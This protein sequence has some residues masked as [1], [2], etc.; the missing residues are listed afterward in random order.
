MTGVTKKTTILVIYFCKALVILKVS[1]KKG[2]SLAA[3]LFFLTYLSF[4]Q[5]RPRPEINLD[6]FIQ[7]IFPLQQ[8]NINYED[9]YESLFQLYQHPINLNTATY[10]ELSSLYVLS[11]AQIKSLLTHRTQYGDLLSIYELQA[12]AGFDMTTIQQLLPFIEVRQKFNAKSLYNNVGHINDHYLV[13][14]SSQTL[15]KSRAYKENKYPGSPQQLYARYR[16]SSPR[17]FQIG[18]VAEKDAGEKNYLDFYSFHLQLKNKGNLK[19]LILGDYQL[20]F[21]QGLVLGAGFFLGKG[22]EA[23]TT[24]RRSNIGARPYGSL[25]EGGYFRGIAATYQLKRIELTAFYSY[26][27]RDAGI[28]ETDAGREEYFSSVLASGYHRTETEVAR[29]NQLTEQNIGMN[30]AFRFNNGYI[31]ATVLH[32]QFDAILMRIPRLYNKFE[33]SGKQNTVMSTNFSYTWQNFNFFGEAARSASGGTGIAGGL[34]AALSK[35]LEGAMHLRY[36]ARNFH[37]FYANALAEGS[38]NINEQG[39][40]W[41]LKYSPKKNL[42]FSAFYDRFKFPWLRYLVD[43]PSHGFDYL[44]RASYQLN[45]RTLLYAQYHAEYKGKNLPDNTTPTDIVVNTVRENI[46]GNFD[47][48]IHRNFKIQSRV[49]VNTFQYEGRAKSTGY[50]IMQDVEGSIKRLYLKGRI[51]YF[52][53][54]DYDSRIYAFENTVLYAVSFPA[55]FGKGIRVYLNGRYALNQHLELWVRYARTQ[56]KS[57]DS[58][59]SGNDIIAGNHKSDISL[60]I[61]YKF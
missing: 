42:T 59:G 17:D 37:S 56:M 9:L 38:R 15:E 20:Q 50:A 48:T 58:I 10:E 5:T 11:V 55:Y 29:K 2:F 41:G 36:Y 26:I 14:R 34:V 6:E 61:R 18:L 3:G 25:L 1:K 54:D 22:S 24:I 43:A 46:L 52:A 8:E 53:T 60:Q 49:Q 33:F 32:T 21:G 40:Y 27:K 4:G 28:D 13:L 23:V 47:Y 39:I 35:Q 44:L 19:N 57:Q 12:V 51:A 30:A 45:K 7:R 16:L 31:G